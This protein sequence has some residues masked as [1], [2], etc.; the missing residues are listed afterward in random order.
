MRELVKP[1]PSK[2]RKMLGA[3]PFLSL[4]RQIP[5]FP[6]KINPLLWKTAIRAMAAATATATFIALQ[7]CQC[8]TM[9]VSFSL[10]LSFGASKRRRP[11]V[12]E[13]AGEATEEEQQQVDVRRLQP[14]AVREEGL[15]S[16]LHGQGR[17]QVRPVL[18]HVAP[19]LGSRSPRSTA[20]RKRRSGPRSCGRQR[21]EEAEEKRLERVST[22]NKKSATMKKVLVF[23]R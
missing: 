12:V 16:G 22:S 15:R 4:N 18:Q 8:S 1:K 7:C 11:D 13:S 10:S 17:P 5:K 3:K 14:E 23:S 20:R 21:W 9:Q 2:V 6:G 19:L